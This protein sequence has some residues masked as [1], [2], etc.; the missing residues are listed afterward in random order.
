VRIIRT[1]T[2]AEISRGRTAGV[3]R[4]GSTGRRPARS[5]PF[6]HFYPELEPTETVE[7]GYEAEK[8][9]R[10]DIR[11]TQEHLGDV[12]SGGF[13][14]GRSR[15]FVLAASVPG[16]DSAFSRSSVHLSMEQAKAVQR[17]HGY[18]ALGDW[19]FEPGGDGVPSDTDLRGWAAGA[20]FAH[21]RWIGLI[22]HPSRTWRPEPEI[23]GWQT[24]RLPDGQMLTERVKLAE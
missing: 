13:L 2:P 10:S 24:V 6:P 17:Q 23:T 22:V 4:S 11:W 9:I 18:P 5:T 19:H 3:S 20:R 16:G 15:G 1:Y 21:D 14:F 8:T 7:L 12:E